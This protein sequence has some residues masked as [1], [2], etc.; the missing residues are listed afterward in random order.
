MDFS[1]SDL[2]KRSAAQILYFIKSG[3]KPKVTDRML[4]GSK[5]QMDVYNDILGSGENAFDEMQGVYHCGDDNIY[6]CIDI[7]KPDG[8]IEVK[9]VFGDSDNI[10]INYDKWYLESSLLQCAVYKSL[11]MNMEGN[12]LRTAQFRVNEGVERREIEVDTNQ[13]YY[14]KFGSVGTFEVRVKNSEP[15]LDFLRKKIEALSDFE[16]ARAFDEKYRHNEF[17]ILSQY[18]E[19]EHKEL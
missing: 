2:C 10:A 5:Y 1:A 16:S 17:K 12:K 11:L 13:P 15:I 19:Y 6:F 14:L 8:F 9:S 7:V 3:T 18:F 4:M